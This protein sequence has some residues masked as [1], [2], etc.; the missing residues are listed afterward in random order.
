ML[1]FP[2]HMSSCAPAAIKH[3]GSHRFIIEKV[4]FFPQEDF[5]CGPSSLAGVLNYWGVSAAPEDIAHEIFSETARGTLTVDM[6]IY[7][8]KKGLNATQYKSSLQDLKKNISSGYPVIVLVDYGISLYQVNHFMV[9][10]GYDDRGFFVN[11][12]KKTNKFLAEEDFLKSWEKTGYW[13]LLI[14]K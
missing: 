3:D 13:T 8:Q 12:G 9:V 5:Q 10:V 11:S 1:L 2:L 4:P 6:V 14:R 7:A